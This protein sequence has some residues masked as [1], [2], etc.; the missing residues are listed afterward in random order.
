MEDKSL[1]EMDGDQMRQMIADYMEKGFLSNIVAMF[2][3]DLSLYDLVGDLLKDER[4]RV[5]M[6]V[7]ALMEEL[8]QMNPDD[9]KSAIPSLLP[10]LSHGTPTIRGDAAYLVGLIGDK[11]ERESLVPLLSDPNPQV[12]EI[13]KDI[14][15]QS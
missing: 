10:L 13:V 15:E 9:A 1:Q 6:G 4:F 5:R 8:H 12:I 3:V 2:K 7:T 11:K 14:L